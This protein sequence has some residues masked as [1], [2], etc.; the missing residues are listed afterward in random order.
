MIN[1]SAFNI[2]NCVKLFIININ[3]KKLKIFK[4]INKYKAK[5]IKL[6]VS[7]YWLGHVNVAKRKKNLFFFCCD[8]NLVQS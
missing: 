1:I 8:G 4:R 3:K 6:L 5:Q 7:H 2:W